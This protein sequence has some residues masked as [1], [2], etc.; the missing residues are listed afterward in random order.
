MVRWLLNSVDS[1]EPATYA[2]QTHGRVKDQ[3]LI[4]LVP[5]F[6][7]IALLWQM[8]TILIPNMMN[9]LARIGV[10]AFL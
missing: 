9:R 10:R 3:L 1:F 7:C 8:F 5:C 2:R 4:L 6:R